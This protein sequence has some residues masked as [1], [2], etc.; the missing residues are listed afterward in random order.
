MNKHQVIIENR[1]EGTV[2]IDGII[3]YGFINC[4]KCPSCDNLEFI[5]RIVMLT[6]A[7]HAMPGLNLHATIHTVNF[8]KIDHPN[9]S[10]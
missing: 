2:D 7:L 6:S 9:L 3:I 8:V 10:I 4:S 1:D 5:M